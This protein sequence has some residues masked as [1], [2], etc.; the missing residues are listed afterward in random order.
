M[1][2][3]IEPTKKEILDELYNDIVYWRKWLK[4]HLKTIKRYNLQSSETLSSLT[5]KT[6]EKILKLQIRYKKLSHEINN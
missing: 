4:R 1:N 5:A 6:T 3:L 2:Y